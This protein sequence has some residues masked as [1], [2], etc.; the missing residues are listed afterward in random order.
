MFLS[1]LKVPILL[2][3]EEFITLTHNP[4]ILYNGSLSVTIKIPF[5]ENAFGPS[6]E[7]SFILFI[8]LVGDLREMRVFFR[9]L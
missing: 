2:K 1:H 4:P 5:N 3:R 9:E 7:S 6:R 8:I